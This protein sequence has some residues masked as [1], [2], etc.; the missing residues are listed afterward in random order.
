MRNA[1]YTLIHLFLLVTMLAI[2]TPTCIWFW[3]RPNVAIEGETQQSYFLPDGK[4]IVVSAISE[5]TRFVVI[6]IQL[7]ESFEL[8]NP[9]LD[10]AQLLNRTRSSPL[11]I[12]E[13]RGRDETLIEAKL[14]NSVVDQLFSRDEWNLLRGQPHPVWDPVLFKLNI[15]SATADDRSFRIAQDGILLMLSELA[16]GTD[17]PKRDANQ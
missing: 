17:E 8:M 9:G 5:D 15:D 6:A 7:D 1:K 4:R 14:A 3:R 12:L 16:A 11:C 2:I 13:V 10:R